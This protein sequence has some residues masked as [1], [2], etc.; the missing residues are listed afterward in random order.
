MKHDKTLAWLTN[1]GYIKTTA[2]V[3][4]ILY[5]VGTVAHLYQPTLGLMTAMTPWFLLVCGLAVIW[6]SIRTGGKRFLIWGVTVY[7]LTFFLEALGVATGL[8]FG[9][10]RYGPTLGLAAFG[11]PLVIAF[12]WAV[13]VYGA[14]RMARRRKRSDFMVAVMTGAIATM[15][16][17]IMEPVAIRLDYWN[18]A[19][20]HIPLQNYLAWFVIA[21]VSSF[22]YLKLM[23]PGIRRVSG[24]DT[25]LKS[26]DDDQA[27]ENLTEG[28]G[29][30]AGFYVLVQAGFFVALRLGWILGF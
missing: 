26:S 28:A 4:V 12:N 20:G 7:V 18:W 29:S 30:L 23:V 22:A 11:V 27:G 8:V 17:W 25:Y 16:D 19:G 1:L 21:T 24:Y 2:V 9:E 3:M 13:V 14:V 5:I 15:F 6:P 10:Y